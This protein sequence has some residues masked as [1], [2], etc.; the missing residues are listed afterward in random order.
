MAIM[1]TAQRTMVV[2]TGKRL[3]QEGCHFVNGARGDTPGNA[4]TPL[5]GPKDSVTLATLN[6]TT[7]SPMVQAAKSW[8]GDAVC[9]GRFRKVGGKILPKSS[10]ALSKY[11]KDVKGMAKAVPQAALPPMSV[12]SQGHLLT[13]R[14]VNGGIILGE[15]CIGRRHFDC[16]DFVNFCYSIALGRKWQFSLDQYSKGIAGKTAKTKR[17]NLRSGDIILRGTAHSGIVYKRSD[18]KWRVLEAPGGDDG[19]ID[20]PFFERDWDERVRVSFF[21]K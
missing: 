3:V 5:A 15:T 10:S 19:L 2:D 21:R 20:S 16:V 4:D 9:K 14:S 11:L 8:K 13:P 12:S 1:T 18:G 17:I 7:A 6:S